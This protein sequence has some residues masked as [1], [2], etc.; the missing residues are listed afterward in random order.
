MNTSPSLPRLALQR[1]R[2]LFV[3]PEADVRVLMLLTAVMFASGVFHVGVWLLDG[4][5]LEG[6]V[7]WRKPISFGLSSGLLSLSI[8]WITA[9]LPAT[10]ARAWW[11]RVYSASLFIE[12]AL[13]TMQRWRGVGSHFNVGTAFDTIVFALMGVLIMAVV[14]ALVGLTVLLYRAADV[15]PDA[16]AAG[17]F[18]LGLLHVA[19]FVGVLI[20]VHGRMVLAAQA[21]VPGHIAGAGV[22]K[23]PHGIAM[24][25]LQVLPLLAFVLAWRGVPLAQRTRWV[26]R[27]GLGYALIVA[28]M[29]AQ[30]LLGMPP[31]Q[32]GLPLIA[33]SVPGLVLLGASAW[34]VFRP[35]RSRRLAVGVP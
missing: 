7:S 33:L 14:V 2:A 6:P 10:N 28:A 13:I 24:H 32:L 23:V 29:F 3:H 12:V 31:T 9:L 8:A 30:A 4:S 25:A 26:I 5:S 27:A 18:G 19:S 34:Q 15:S 22:L 16:R 17:L 11:V 20:I 35:V 21:G 1:L